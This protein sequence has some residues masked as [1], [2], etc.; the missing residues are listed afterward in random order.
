DDGLNE[1]AERREQRLK[2][3]RKNRAHG[4]I[5]ET[6]ALPAGE[7]EKN[8]TG[9]MERRKTSAAARARRDTDHGFESRTIATLTGESRN[10]QI[11]LPFLVDRR[12]Q[13]L[14]RTAAARSEMSAVG[15]APR[16]P[17]FKQ[18]HC[19]AAH[20]AGRTLHVARVYANAQPIARCGPR[21]GNAPIANPAD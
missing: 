10:K 8:P 13:L 5:D 2:P 9:R 20:R 6:T 1:V 11:E 15:C 3:R 19:I 4:E 7:T 18:H 17:G 21:D 12:R 16:G 14:G